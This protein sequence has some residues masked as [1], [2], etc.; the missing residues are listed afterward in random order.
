MDILGYITFQVIQHSTNN[1]KRT[2][3]C[4]P[5]Y[6]EFVD[7]T[8]PDLRDLGVAPSMPMIDLFSVHLM[9]FGALVHS[10]L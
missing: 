5:P 3:G 8:P 7:S 2:T 6:W 1:I 10:S 4:E 9:R